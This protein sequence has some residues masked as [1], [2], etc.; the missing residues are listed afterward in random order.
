MPENQADHAAEQSLPR[1]LYLLKMLLACERTQPLVSNEA[2]QSSSPSL[3][4]L[5]FREHCRSDFKQSLQATE[6]A[7]STITRFV[8]RVRVKGGGMNTSLQA[9]VL[10]SV[11]LVTVLFL[12]TANV[13]AQA[14]PEY[15]ILC[16]PNDGTSAA[17]G[18]SNEPLK[19]DLKTGQVSRLTSVERAIAFKACD[20][21]VVL[22][23][24]ADAVLTIT[25]NDNQT[26]GNETDID[27]GGSCFDQCAIGQQ[28]LVQADCASGLC[29]ALYHVCEPVP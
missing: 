27:C 20:Q 8:G 7:D 2:T 24:L 4:W 1:P 23:D 14:S 18:F 17:G 11:I 16:P 3:R 21:D 9:R 25:C 13:F 28:C 22:I 5:E 10:I 29:S 6:Q 19:Q 26:N 15:E 12:L